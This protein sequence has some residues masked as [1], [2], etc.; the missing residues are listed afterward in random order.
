MPGMTAHPMPFDLVGRG[1]PFQ[2]LP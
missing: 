2:T 1:G